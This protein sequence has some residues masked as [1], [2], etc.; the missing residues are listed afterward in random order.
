MCNELIISTNA[1]FDLAKFDTVGVYFEKDVPNKNKVNLKYS[2]VYRLATYA[3]NNCSCFFRYWQ[4][5]LLIDSFKGE[6]QDLQEWL[7]ENPNDDHIIN[8]RF[9]FQVIK[10]LVNQGYC[11]DSF[12]S[13]FDIMDITPTT[14]KIIKVNEIKKEKF[15][16]FC[17]YYYEYQK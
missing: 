2:N 13:E 5:D 15:T 12:C 10:N 8:T 6:F 11:V 9:L 14:A 16:F 3:P 17:N 4:D 7:D 1:P